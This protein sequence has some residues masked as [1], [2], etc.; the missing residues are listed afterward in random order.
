MPNP[1]TKRLRSL[2]AVFRA[3]EARR[4]GVSWRDLYRARDEGVLL[5]LSRGV[6]QLREAAGVDQLD[7]VV[8]C[9]RAPRAMV[10][11]G[12]ALTYWD[13][14]DDIPPWVD[15]AVPVGSHRPRI[16]YPPVL[17]H[18]FH[19]STFD[20]GRV[21]VEVA[22]GARFAITD[23]ERTVVDAFRMRHGLG[24]DVGPAALRR[25]LRGTHP[26]PARVLELASALR[27][28]SRVLAALRMLQE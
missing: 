4:A 20:L 26:S 3:D 24:G 7:F 21:E 25:Y 2:G 13:L 10:C 11:L 22:P 19:A 8:V 16:D 6:Y 23:P 15:I 27:V 9:A 28:R 18:V 5:E 17:V 12:S 1:P 14:T